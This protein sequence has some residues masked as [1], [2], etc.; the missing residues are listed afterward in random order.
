MVRISV[1][2]LRA[3]CVELAVVST[4]ASGSFQIAL[5]YCPP[6]STRDLDEL[7][8]VLHQLTL[9]SHTP[10]LLVGDF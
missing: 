1:I 6:G 10:S 5:C 7:E 2:V 9:H 4:L 8:K 3:R